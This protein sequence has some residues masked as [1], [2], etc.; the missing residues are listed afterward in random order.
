MG[1]PFSDT[2]WRQKMLFYILIL[3]GLYGWVE[4]E[5]LIFIGSEIGGLASFLG[6]FVT[7]FIGMGLLRSQ[8]RAV[9]A[10]W[11]ANLTR[12]E[13]ETASLASGLSLLVGALLMLLPGYVTDAMGILCFIPGLRFLIG[14]ALLTRFKLVNA[15]NILGNR[16]TSGFNTASDRYDNTAYSND[17]QTSSRPK[18]LDGD[19]I[20]G[21]FE[22]KD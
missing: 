22:K 4:F 10:K 1:C 18:N 19:I 12:R 16:F 11:Q 9:L 3:F 6:I 13:A 8:G 5:A 15:Q 14:R 2:S 7:A 20:E 21:D 17:R